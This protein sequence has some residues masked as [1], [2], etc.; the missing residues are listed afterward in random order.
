MTKYLLIN[1]QDGKEPGYVAAPPGYAAKPGETVVSE[2]PQGWVYD[3]TGKRLRPRTDAELLA[4]ARAEKRAEMDARAA[5][6]MA[7]VIPIYRAILHLAR[8][9]LDAPFVALR[10]VDEKLATKNLSVEAAATPETV[11]LVKWDP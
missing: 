10:A 7:N 11:N 6:D 9:S 4:K 5:A 3:A 2:V 1:P 8:G